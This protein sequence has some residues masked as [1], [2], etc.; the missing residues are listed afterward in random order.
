MQWFR[1]FSSHKETS[2]QQ[3]VNDFIHSH[4]TLMIKKQTKKTIILFLKSRLYSHI[5]PS[6]I[7]I[8]S[9]NIKYTKLF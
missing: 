8:H 3:K 1:P 5:W 6:K 7:S 9:L 4:F 2:K